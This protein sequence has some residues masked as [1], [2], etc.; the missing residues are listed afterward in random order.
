VPPEDGALARLCLELKHL[1]RHAGKPSLRRMEAATGH[2]V[3]HTTI[4]EALRCNRLPTWPVLEWIVRALD[5]DAE[6]FREMWKAVW[7]EEEPLPPRPGDTEDLGIDEPAIP[8]LE[9]IEEA[10][11]AQLEAIERAAVLRH[12]MESL[13][14]QLASATN[15]VADLNDRMTTL[16]ATLDQL[17]QQA[18]ADAS[19][20][21]HLEAEIA[22]LA[23]E[24]DDLK[25]DR[26]QLYEQ[27]KAL[28]KRLRDTHEDEMDLLRQAAQISAQRAELYRVLAHSEEML[29]RRHEQD[30]QRER[31]HVK[32]LQAQLAAR[33][34]PGSASSQYLAAGLDPAKSGD[35]AYTVTAPYLRNQALILGDT[36][37][38]LIHQAPT[39]AE[40]L[41]GRARAL[42]LLA[43][44]V[45][46]TASIDVGPFQRPYVLAVV[47]AGIAA[48]DPA[49]AS[50]LA[51]E[52]RWIALSTDEPE[53]WGLPDIVRALAVADPDLAERIARSIEDPVGRA[54]AL[55][56]VAG[57]FAA[58]RPDRG[59]DLARSIDRRGWRESALEGVVREVALTDPERAAR[60]AHTIQEPYYRAPS[61][62]AVAA[63]VAATDPVRAERIARTIQNPDYKDYRT[64]ALAAVA[65]AVAVTDPGR[66]SRLALE[67][68]TSARSA[69]DRMRYGV[70]TDVAKALAVADPDR[71]ERIARTIEE[72]DNHQAVALSMIVEALAAEDP[73]RAE[74]IAR[75]IKEGGNWNFHALM[76]VAEALAAKDPD[77]AERIARIIRD[78]G[79]RAQPLAKI[80]GSIMLRI[81]PPHA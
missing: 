19:L 65:A 55:S 39:E 44:A 69:N 68:E 32:T 67:A 64:P 46:A 63:A 36:A 77:R 34:N 70:L 5:G 20:R 49:R 38:T 13:R 16:S 43:E 61:L 33:A 58:V 71:A 59:E 66:A 48:A 22:R 51:D 56:Y 81:G 29:R 14:G 12:D 11:H 10:D 45:Q 28:E 18:D 74:R 60:I 6:H 57:P 21:N 40:W 2:K 53:Q 41:F 54:K 35:P 75:T 27:I 72:A 50:L 23:K 15:Q 73:D 37:K 52:A 17:R 3:S 78:P 80:A 31:T 9:T 8:R 47:A 62:A 76:R 30:L 7:Q 42:Q 4:N 24:R 79:F 26:D 25:K 1:H